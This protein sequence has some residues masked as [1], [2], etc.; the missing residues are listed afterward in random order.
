MKTK[1]VWQSCSEF[2][3]FQ[4]TFGVKQNNDSNGMLFFTELDKAI[5]YAVMNCQCEVIWTNT[6]IVITVDEMLNHDRAQFLREII[7]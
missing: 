1:D 3:S 7:K 5:S 4:N 6:D 2:D